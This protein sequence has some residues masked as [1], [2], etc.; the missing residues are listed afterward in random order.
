MLRP[1]STIDEDSSSVVQVMV[2]S[3]E[4][5]VDEMLVRDGLVVSI[6]NALLAARLVA[7]VN[8]TIALVAASAIVPETD[9]TVRSSDVSPAC[10]V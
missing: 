8:E 10:T 2:A 3:V 7:G 1:Y 5:G 4:V 9:E 6:T